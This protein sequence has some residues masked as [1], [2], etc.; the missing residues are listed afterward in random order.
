MVGGKYTY[1]EVPLFHWISE[2]LGFAR[3]HYDRVGHFTQGF[4]PALIAREILVRLAVVRGPGWLSF[5]IVCICL[6]LSAV[7]E[8]IEWWGALLFG[9]SA[10]HFLGTQGDTWDTQWDM[11]LCGVGAV[12][13]LLLLSRV[14][15]RAMAAAPEFRGKA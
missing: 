15:D 4:V 1:A 3:N 8:F 5:L 2:V 6:S 7:Y 9:E 14:H 12:A 11:F 10:E 13:A